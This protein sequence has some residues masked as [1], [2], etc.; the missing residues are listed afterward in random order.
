MA[1]ELKDKLFADDDISTPCAD[2]LYYLQERKLIDTL[3]GGTKAM[4]KAGL[5][6]L[7][8][9]EAESDLSLIHI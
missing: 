4:R 2:Y 9:E 3:M 8:Q 7:P 6:Y 5:T 1:T